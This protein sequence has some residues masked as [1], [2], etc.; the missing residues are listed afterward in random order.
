VDKKTINSSIANQSFFFGLIC[1][2]IASILSL[3]CTALL[4]VV[5]LANIV[6]IFLLSTFLIATSLGRNA[7][8]FSARI[9]L[10][11][12]KSEVDELCSKLNLSF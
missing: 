5:D 9:K 11:K 2:G 3:A 4:G 7:A 12:Y 6:M 8:I 10:E 1:I